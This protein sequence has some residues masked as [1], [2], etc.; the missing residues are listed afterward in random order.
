MGFLAVP[1]GPLRNALK[2]SWDSPVLHIFRSSTSEKK[3]S[4]RAPPA[5][6][7]PINHSAKTTP[8]GI[9][10]TSDHTQDDID[11]LIK[12]AS[13]QPFPRDRRSANIPLD[14]KVEKNGS[15]GGEG[16]PEGKSAVH[17]NDEKNSTANVTENWN[18]SELHEGEAVSG[19]WGLVGR[20][21]LFRSRKAR[22]GK[23]GGIDL[24]KV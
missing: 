6:P 19:V 4:N 1:N 7:T 23:G 18:R 9:A 15:E 14:S 12:I 10:K 2:D 16:H 21:P 3:G 8:P 20:L 11:P 22:T 13:N 5:P 17:F 24:D